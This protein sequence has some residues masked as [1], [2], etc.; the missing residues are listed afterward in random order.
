MVRTLT[1]RRGLGGRGENADA[2]GGIGCVEDYICLDEGMF[3]MKSKLS[4]KDTYTCAL[5][6]R[7]QAKLTWAGKMML[8]I[9]HNTFPSWL[10]N[11]VYLP[12]AQLNLAMTL[13][14][15]LLCTGKRSRGNTNELII[16]KCQACETPSNDDTYHHTGALTTA[17]SSHELPPT[18]DIMGIKGLWPL[19]APVSK[20]V[21]LC[22]LTVERGFINNVASI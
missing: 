4:S 2:V 14:E 22:N 18:G 16:L 19:L 21:S 6:A 20:S 7:I 11:S 3:L 13:K 15:F 17:I 10:D 8:Q 5:P 1:R 9:E 12:I